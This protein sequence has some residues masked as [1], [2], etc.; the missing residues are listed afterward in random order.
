[1]KCLSDSEVLKGKGKVFYS[2]CYR[3]PSMKANTPEFENVLAD[4]EILY[5]NILKNTPYACFFAVDFNAHSLSW[6]PN[7]ATKGG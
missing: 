1:M 4:C 3:S 2:V 7:G 6:W 5:T